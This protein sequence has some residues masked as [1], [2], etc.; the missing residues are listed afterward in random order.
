M[1]INRFGVHGSNRY[2]IAKEDLLWSGNR[3]K[4]PFVAERIF[5]TL[6]GSMN[7]YEHFSKPNFANTF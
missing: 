7:G 2:K 5:L 3:Y 6:F 1:T 4:K